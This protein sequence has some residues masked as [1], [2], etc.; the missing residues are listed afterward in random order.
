MCA[1]SKPTSYD[2]LETIAAVA[3]SLIS[4]TVNDEIVKKKTIEKAQPQLKDNVQK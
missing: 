1:T 4:T 2:E 3:S